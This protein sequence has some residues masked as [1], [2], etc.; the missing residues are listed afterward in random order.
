MASLFLRLGRGVIGIEDRNHKPAKGL[1]R[2]V[3]RIVEPVVDHRDRDFRM[4]LPQ[5]AVRRRGAGEAAEQHPLGTHREHPAP[6][7]HHPRTWPRSVRQ[8]S[9]TPSRGSTEIASSS[10]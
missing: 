10:S 2:G 4:A 7:A 1:C 6:A 9:G 5:L 3:A 8:S